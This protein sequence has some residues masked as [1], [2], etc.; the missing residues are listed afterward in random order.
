[1]SWDSILTPLHSSL[2]QRATL[3]LFS[4][5]VGV[6]VESAF[7]NHS[8]TKMANYSTKKPCDVI[9]Q[10]LFQCQ[11]LWQNEEGRKYVLPKTVGDVTESN[12]KWPHVAGFPDGLVSFSVC[13]GICEIK[14]PFTA[15]DM[16]L[17]DYK[18]T[19]GSCLINEGL[20]L[21]CYHDNNYQE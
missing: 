10:L 9:N 18:R 21:V 16:T 14:C 12:I 5:S 13:C 4:N 2:P 3:L 20:V 19:K 11:I 7:L 8:P 15:K 1:M 6:K 17:E